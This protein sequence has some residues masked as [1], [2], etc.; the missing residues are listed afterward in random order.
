MK[1]FFLLAAA[2]LVVFT[3]CTK[4]EE[5][6]SVP[7]RKI[8]FQAASYVP[9]TKANVSVLKEF[10]AFKCKAF[11]HAAGYTAANETQDMFG[12]NGETIKPYDSNDAELTNLTAEST[13]VA[14]WAPSHD[15]YWPKDASSYVNFVAWYDKNGAPTTAT[16]TSLVW[17]IDGS[18]RSLATSDNILF[19]DEAWHFK[20][21][22]SPATYGMNGVSEGVP[23]LFHHALAQLCIQAKVTQA[24]DEKTP[25]HTWDVTLEDIKLSGVYNKGTLTLSNTEP[26][27]S[28][29]ASTVA[30]T[31]TTT[32]IWTPSGDTTSISMA[33]VTTPLTTDTV[34][35]L[36]MQNVLPQTVTDDVVLKFKYKISYKYD[37][38]EYAH[39][40][41]TENVQLNHITDAIDKWEM[42]KKITYVITIDPVKTVIRI[43]PAMVDWEEVA[44]G[45]TTL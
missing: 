21:N 24:T 7:A 30:W 27:G 17:T 20:Q 6:D 10:S 12:A 14:Y 29:T 16:E 5:A 4:I 33:N 26:S 35:V 1:K 38:T 2:A 8:T 45:S 39:E 44:G 23:M 40:K 42:N 41:I 19:A 25:A 28:T 43:D 15:Y 22:T 37:G 9:Q 13:N 34:S 18:T 36:R 3:A 31:S 11:L 32:G